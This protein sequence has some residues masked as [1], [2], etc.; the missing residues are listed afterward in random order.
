MT[1]C[2]LMGG[3]HLGHLRAFRANASA[4]AFG[5]M[6]V[7]GGAA[8]HMKPM[9]WQLSQSKESLSTNSALVGRCSLVLCEGFLYCFF[10]NSGFCKIGTG[11]ASGTLQGYVYATNTDVYREK[12]QSSTSSGNGSK[13]GTSMEKTPNTGFSFELEVSDSPVSFK[14]PSPAQSNAAANYAIRKERG[15][16]EYEKEKLEGCLFCNSNRVFMYS[17]ESRYDGDT[18]SLGTLVDKVSLKL[19]PGVRIVVK[20][21]RRKYSAVYSTRTYIFALRA[22]ETGVTKTRL[23]GKKNEKK[24]SPGKQGNTGGWESLR[25][26]NPLQFDVYRERK[27]CR[28]LT[29]CR[30]GDKCNFYHPPKSSNDNMLGDCVQVTFSHT[31]TLKGNPTCPAEKEWLKENGGKSELFGLCFFATTDSNGKPLIAA[32]LSTKPSTS[33]VDKKLNS[34]IA[35]CVYFDAFDGQRRPFVGHSKSGASRRG[36]QSQKLQG[37]S[38]LAKHEKVKYFT[39]HVC[40]DSLNSTISYIVTNKALSGRTKSIEVSTLPLLSGR[41]PGKEEKRV[42]AVQ[43]RLYKSKTAPPM[44][45]SMIILRELHRVATVEIESSPYADSSSQKGR[46][47]TVYCDFSVT[48]MEQISDLLLFLSTWVTDSSSNSK[49]GDKVGLLLSLRWTLSLCTQCVLQCAQKQISEQMKSA[50]SNMM[51]ILYDKVMIPCR[52]AW[53]KFPLLREE[54][55]TSCV[56]ILFAA[57]GL[58]FLECNKV[59]YARTL[60]IRAFQRNDTPFINVVSKLWSVNPSHSW[61]E[62]AGAIL[63]SGDGPIPFFDVLVKSCT[64]ADSKNLSAITGVAGPRISSNLNVLLCFHKVFLS[65]A[66]ANDAAVA[67]PSSAARSVKVLYS[68]KYSRTTYKKA[69]TALQ[70]ASNGPYVLKASNGFPTWKASNVLLTEGKW[71]YEIE[72]C[73]DDVKGYPQV[74][75]ASSDFDGGDGENKGVGDDSCSWGIDGE[76]VC[77]WN[78]E[79]N[80]ENRKY[81]KKW[82]VGDR[83][84]CAINLDNKSMEFYVNNLSQG[85][86]YENINVSNGVCPAFTF[87]GRNCRLFLKLYFGNKADPFKYSPPEGHKSIH[88]SLLEQ[89]EKETMR[90]NLS[91]TWTTTDVVDYFGILCRECSKYIDSCSSASISYQDL[92][93]TSTASAVL[94]SVALLVCQQSNSMLEPL[95]E[96]L[97][98]AKSLLGFFATCSKSFDQFCSTNS[99]AEDVGLG[100]LPSDAFDLDARSKMQNPTKLAWPVHL[101]TILVLSVNRLSTRLATAQVSNF[102]GTHYWLDSVLFGNSIVQAAPVNDF[103]ESIL[104]ESGKGYEWL[105][106]C[107]TNRPRVGMQYRLLKRSEK[108]KLLNIEALVMAALLRHAPEHIFMHAQLQSEIIS[109]GEDDKEVMARSHDA[110]QPLWIAAWSVVSETRHIVNKLSEWKHLF[111]SEPGGERDEKMVGFVESLN[112]FEKMHLWV[113][114]GKEPIEISSLDNN[115]QYMSRL[116]ALSSETPSIFE[117]DDSKCLDVVFGL[118]DSRAKLIIELKPAPWRV[119]KLPLD[120]R[121]FQNVTSTPKAGF[122][123]TNSRTKQESFKRQDSSSAT[124]KGRSSR[125]WSRVVTSLKRS[126][127]SINRGNSKRPNDTNEHGVDIEFY[128]QIAKFFKSSCDPNQ[129]RDSIQLRRKAAHARLAGIQGITS[130]LTHYQ[131]N[132]SKFILLASLGRNTQFSWGSAILK[133]AQNGVFFSGHPGGKRVTVPHILNGIRGCGLELEKEL[134]SA[135]FDL[136]NHSVKIACDRVMPIYT[137]C[138]ALQ[139]LGVGFLPDD[140]SLIQKYDL[141]SNL[142]NIVSEMRADENYSEDK[143]SLQR[144]SWEILLLISKS[145]LASSGKLDLKE[146]LL[147]ALLRLLEESANQS[148]ASGHRSYRLLDGRQTGEVSTLIWARVQRRELEVQ[149]NV[150]VLYIHR[151]SFLQSD[152]GV[153]YGKNAVR[154]CLKLLIHARGPYSTRTTR[155]ALRF[156]SSCLQHISPKVI[157]QFSETNSEGQANDLWLP[158]LLLEALGALTLGTGG[159]GTR[160]GACSAGGSGHGTVSSEDS[161]VKDRALELFA[162]SIKDAFSSFPSLTEMESLLSPEDKNGTKS[163]ESNIELPTSTVL[164]DDLLWDNS[165]AEQERENTMN[166]IASDAKQDFKNWID[167][168]A[169]SSSILPQPEVWEVA[170]DK[171]NVRREPSMDHEPIGRHRR[172]TQLKVVDKIPAEGIPKGQWLRLQKAESGHGE[173]WV[174]SR[175]K[176]HNLLKPVVRKTYSVVLY[177]PSNESPDIFMART[178]DI[179]RLAIAHDVNGEGCNWPSRGWDSST[180]PEGQFIETCVQGMRENGRGLIMRNCSKIECETVAARLACQRFVTCVIDNIPKRE[181]TKFDRNLKLAENMAKR[182]SSWY[183]GYASMSAAME[184]VKMLRFLVSGVDA[185]NDAPGDHRARMSWAHGTCRAISKAY[186]DF[187][188][189]ATGDDSVTARAYGALL[190]L[191]GLTTG[192]LHL[193]STVQVVTGPQSHSEG[194][195]VRYNAGETTADVLL[196]DHSV[197]ET[198]DIVAV[199]PTESAQISEDITLNSESVTLNLYPTLRSILEGK[200]ALKDYA[201]DQKGTSHRSWLV[202]TFVTTALRVLGQL[203]QISFTPVLMGVQTDEMSSLLKN[204]ASLRDEEEDKAMAEINCFSILST[205]AGDISCLEELAI[206]ARQQVLDMRHG[207]QK[208]LM[209]VSSYAEVDKATFG[210]LKHLFL[211]RGFNRFSAMGTILHQETGK[212]NLSFDSP[213]T[214]VQDG[215]LSKIARPTK[216]SWPKASHSIVIADNPIPAYLNN[217]YFEIE[218]RKSDNTNF[219]LHNLSGFFVGLWVGNATSIEAG[220][221]EISADVADSVWYH[222]GNGKSIV[223]GKVRP[224]LCFEGVPDLKKDL[225]TVQSIVIGCGWDLVNHSVFF[226]LDGSRINSKAGERRDSDNPHKLSPT[227]VEGFVY[228]AVRFLGNSGLK[229]KIMFGNNSSKF[230]YKFPPKIGVQKRDLAEGIQIFKQWLEYKTSVT[231]GLPNGVEGSEN[232]VSKLLIKEQCKSARKNIVD[233]KAC[234]NARRVALE[235]RQ[236]LAQHS[237]S[238]LMLLAQRYNLQNERA[239]TA[240]FEH[241]NQMVDMQNDVDS[242]TAFAQ[243]DDNSHLEVLST[244]EFLSHKLLNSGDVDFLKYPGLEGPSIIA[245]FKEDG[246]LTNSTEMEKK[247][248]VVLIASQKKPFQ[249]QISELVEAGVLGI[250]WIVDTDDK[251]TGGKSNLLAE[252]EPEYLSTLNT[253]LLLLRSKGDTELV[254]GNYR[255]RFSIG[256]RPTKPPAE[257]GNEKKNKK[258]GIEEVAETAPSNGK[259][260]YLMGGSLF[261]TTDEDAEER[262]AIIANEQEAKIELWLAEMHRWLSR[263][264]GIDMAQISGIISHLRN[265]DPD[266]IATMTL[267]GIE[268]KK[269]MPKKP[270]FDSEKFSINLGNTKVRIDDVRIGLCLRVTEQAKANMDGPKPFC[271]GNIVRFVRS[272][273]LVDYRVDS[274]NADGTLS[275]SLNTRDKRPLQLHGVQERHLAKVNFTPGRVSSLS[276]SRIQRQS[277]SN[278]SVRWLSS[279]SVC[280]RR[281]GIVRRVDKSDKEHPL[282]L[283]EFYDPETLGVCRWWFP[284]SSLTYPAERVSSYVESLDEAVVYERALT[285]MYARNILVNS[286][287]QRNMS[288]TYPSSPNT[289]VSSGEEKFVITMAYVVVEIISWYVPIEY[290]GINITWYFYISNGRNRIIFN[291]PLPTLLTTLPNLPY[292]TQPNQPLL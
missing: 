273:A 161:P 25:G 48:H 77:T 129:L 93:P 207:F 166:R 80:H 185:E 114:T 148:S 101:K 145:I 203:Q 277:S 117:G 14:T 61:L 65:Q 96:N 282:V 38:P 110:L 265:G 106:W 150:S 229:A 135:Y 102:Y 221:K 200:G 126:P 118:M 8:N 3:A 132:T 175:N 119:D 51:D 41:N 115:N 62:L 225:A 222:P 19:V 108:T 88:S 284:I 53:L 94:P 50:V 156:L 10:S 195:L 85:V 290:T 146:Q 83:I 198:F 224:D 43:E 7:D 134:N 157:S 202:A 131:S 274:V 74:G 244:E 58:Y 281:T 231:N 187:N 59:E 180:N 138:E 121:S 220:T 266:G 253:P 4:P 168:P 288:I 199:Q 116:C 170:I 178:N 40:I 22:R 105:L 223:S 16:G 287:S 154:S 124:V 17:Q 72:I 153:E 214:V 128:E 24:K 270:E 45:T 242:G 191:G 29:K 189:G 163:T 263:S 193:G 67:T 243:Y 56:K 147:R 230:L 160:D 291:L 251:V 34:G 113:C 32:G 13:K 95:A 174:L 44:E 30:H 208:T 194:I 210:L 64:G 5:G 139:V 269:R 245:N 186:A 91:R 55:Q 234:I 49:K 21:E 6:D 219:A 71:Y 236:I 125:D 162:R 205:A 69:Q 42:S 188:S 197:V 289:N 171:L 136:I 183:G 216:A 73:G 35:Q 228:P 227:S 164:E 11:G 75:W 218:V 133:P 260:S 79:T 261:C 190:V 159:L 70:E 233:A 15:D 237:V 158:L 272:S 141:V 149:Q 31:I 63:R 285:T 258:S 151:N 213:I 122:K 1:T 247:W 240:A 152:G 78:K 278:P 112:R 46:M 104:N 204:I 206:D 279:M 182:P 57:P 12:E 37:I 39:D 36:K 184:I 262:V 28:F 238:V 177:N 107:R 286:W 100:D 211:P 9:V 23:F 255:F 169:Q 196:R 123:R 167:G 176:D 165:V 103:V 86:A 217:F 246:V 239:I 127:S 54:I 209:G 201:K 292:P 192:G 232:E 215:F 259:F 248:C 90:D 143:L 76:R 92:P 68:P 33:N 2:A 84:G 99:S 130:G 81:G 89:S 97:E 226:T 111:R 52:T 250:L 276:Q 181:K 283:L 27:V 47:T 254:G 179:V 20:G 142:A 241:P 264:Q 172:G 173:S 82:S 280:L 26:G 268:D 109:Q 87:S 18:W 137:R 120:R 271:K 275:I 66:F 60:L 257:S 140:F 252:L 249:T 144:E 212:R 155:A 235:L 267:D 256:L 98:A